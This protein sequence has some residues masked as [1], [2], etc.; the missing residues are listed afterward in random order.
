M[1]EFT[2]RGVKFTLNGEGFSSF[3][4][5]GVFL[6]DNFK[7]K[8][9]EELAENNYDIE[10]NAG[11]ME[12]GQIIKIDMINTISGTKGKQ[13]ILSPRTK[14]ILLTMLTMYFNN[15]LLYN[16]MKINSESAEKLNTLQQLYYKKPEMYKIYVT[17]KNGLVLDKSEEYGQPIKIGVAF[18]YIS[19]QLEV[20]ANLKS[21]FPGARIGDECIAIGKLYS[22]PN[23]ELSHFDVGEIKSVVC[24]RRGSEDTKISAT[25][26]QYENMLYKN[27]EKELS[28][29][30]YNI[31]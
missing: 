9:I 5:N 8:F 1:Y 23:K 2:I 7:Y 13:I 15:A 6:G 27:V 3:S 21:V 25:E 4:D 31:E 17:K 30:I 22:I 20:H 11:E 12:V 28:T 29:I 26:N 16:G 10:S 19:M 24:G 14:P 18:H